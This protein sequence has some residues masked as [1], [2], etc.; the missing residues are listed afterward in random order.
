MRFLIP[1]SLVCLGFAHCKMPDP[2]LVGDLSCDAFTS[3][4]YAG[5]VLTPRFVYAS[6]NL[7][8]NIQTM[9]IKED[10]ALEFLRSTALAGA[11]SLAID[12]AGRYLYASGTGGV[13]VYSI[14][15]KDGTLVA[16]NSYTGVGTPGAI[17]VDPSGS[18]IVIPT[19]TGTAICKVR[20]TDCVIS[21]IA[22]LLQTAFRKD[23]TGIFAQLNTG[24]LGTFNL[25]STSLMLTSFGPTPAGGGTATT[26]TGLVFDSSQTHVYSAYQTASPANLS[27]GTVAGD[28]SIGTVTNSPL[29]HDFYSIAMDPKDR[30]VLVSDFN[31]N[32]ILGV[33]R[34]T[35]GSLDPTPLIAVATQASTQ[36]RKIAI[37]PTGTY[38]Y[39]TNTQG[40]SESILT[41]VLSYGT[42]VQRAPLSI[43]TS[44]NTSLGMVVA[45]FFEN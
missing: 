2:C 32:L 31:N 27:A 7:S 16:I 10:G 25:D 38:M 21:P 43:V 42:M 12:P 28:K 3:L 1:L 37:D 9:K 44:N 11:S 35:D 23:A 19:G 30:F 39:V 6:D 45:S 5:P 18:Y 29:A 13:F 33:G 8:G 24:N 26:G 15:H 4:L 22:N 36:M 20:A 34:N 40:G 41:F 14:T 17:S